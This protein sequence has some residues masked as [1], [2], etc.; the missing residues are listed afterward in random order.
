[1][2][3]PRFNKPS[4]VTAPDLVYC[5]SCAQFISVGKQ[6]EHADKHGLQ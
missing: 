4:T 2:I 1:M 5:L 6:K 3:M